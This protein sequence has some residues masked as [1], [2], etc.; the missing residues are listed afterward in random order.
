MAKFTVGMA[1]GGGGARGIAHIGLLQVMAE[2]GLNI[3][4]ISGTSAGALI[5]AMYASRPD[6]FWVEQRFREFLEDRAFK[7]L[8]T[9][10][11]ARRHEGGET[12]GAFGKRLQDHFVVN[13]SLMRQYVIPR[14]TLNN[15]IRFLVP[16]RR[17]QD[18]ELPM[19]VCAADLQSGEVVRYQS[20]DLV[21]ALANSSSIPGVLEAEI[22]SQSILV[23]G[24]VLAP[25]PVRALV[26]KS[27]FI[28]ASEISRQSLRPLADINIYALM[29]RSEQLTQRALARHQ[30]RLAD[31]VLCPDVMDLH[32]SQ[33]G[34]FDELLQ[35][36]RNE[37]QN[38]MAELKGKLRMAKSPIGALRRIISRLARR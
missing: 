9:D 33:F 27:D 14:E 37:A 35:N 8:G 38:R 32:W 7:N 10:R 18:L 28:I 12:V 4:Q 20:G 13:L 26:G 16:A 11:M 23:D 29:M 30:A 24:G 19:V 22:S 17:F 6:P 15:A 36:G 3:D 5:G 31:F 34:A 1:L 2:H 21:L 25:V